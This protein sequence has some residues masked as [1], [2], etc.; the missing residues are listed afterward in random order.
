MGLDVGDWNDSW[1][2]S[3]EVANDVARNLVWLE[4]LFCFFKIP[5]SNKVVEFQIPLEVVEFRI[6]NSTQN[7]TRPKLLD[8]KD[9]TRFLIE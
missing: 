4:S 2:G 8:S 9:S 1:L 6:P 7:K 3:G 5:N